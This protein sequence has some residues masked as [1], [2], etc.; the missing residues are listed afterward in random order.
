MTETE[1]RAAKPEDLLA[2]LDLYG[3][4]T[5]GTPSA[6]PGDPDIVRSALER[7]LAQTDR[8]LLVAVLDGR[9]VGTA[10]LAIVPN[11]SHRRT[12][13][14]VLENI[15]VASAEHRQG[16]TRPLFPEIERIAP[17]AECR[18]VGLL[19]SKARVEAHMLYRS[20][21][22]GAL[23]EGFDLY[24]GQVIELDPFVAE[25]GA[26]VARVL[27]AQRSGRSRRNAP[28]QTWPVPPPAYFSS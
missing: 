6:A 20:V 2:L 1:V 4:L 9:I 24:F 11:T 17:A 27:A 25:I 15:V 23:T 18:K 12:P 7:V 26:H 28:E 13:S 10:D 8:H 22:Y 5:E 19:S 14:G 3:E 16:V 21:G